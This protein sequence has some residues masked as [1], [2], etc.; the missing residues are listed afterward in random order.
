MLLFV[1]HWPSQLRKPQQTELSRRASR[2]GLSRSK[3]ES[4]IGASEF[5]TVDCG[6]PEETFARTRVVDN[7]SDSAGGV[8]STR[9]SPFLLI[10]TCKAILAWD[11]AEV[12]V[13]L[14]AILLRLCAVV[15]F[16]SNGSLVCSGT[17]IRGVRTS[18]DTLRWT[19]CRVAA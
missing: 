8:A 16:G 17:N 11:R 19:P 12:A 3:N 15:A 2:R 4:I 10:A 14:E 6:H 7:S 5:G 18:V 1:T 13:T 9:R